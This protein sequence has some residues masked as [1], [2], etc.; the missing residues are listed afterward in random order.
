MKKSKTLLFIIAL[1]VNSLL[2]FFF[3]IEITFNH[4]LVIHLFL[5][6]LTFLP[7]IAK[8][9]FSKSRKIPPTFFLIIN[10]L[11]MLLI[12]VFLFP[13]ILN[14]SISDKT[15][16]YNFFIAYFFYLFTDIIFKLK[17]T[18]KINM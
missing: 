6:S 17:N 9:I 12:L 11:R 18:N 13:T 8:F 1:I 15:Y 5:F 14:Y 3:K 7:I 2:V 16:I 4:L 10:V